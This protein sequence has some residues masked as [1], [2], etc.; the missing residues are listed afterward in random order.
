MIDLPP[1]FKQALGNGVRTS[2]YPLVRIYKGIRIDDTIPDDAESINLSIKETNISGSAYKPLL[3]NTPSIKSSA[4]IINNKYTISSVSLSISNA[5]F[6]G[7]IFSDDI[8][9]ILNAVVQVYYCANGIDSID[10]CLLVYTGTI[11]R[12][13]Q[14]AETI[15]LELEDA[16]QQILSTQIPSTLI[17]DD[18]TYKEDD[19]GKPYPMVY[20]YVDKSP[21][22]SHSIGEDNL[23][24]LIQ[25]LTKF[26]ID[27]E[28][29]ELEGLWKTP[30][31]GDYGNPFLTSSHPLIDNGYIKEV[32]TLSVYED[33]FI[34]IP[35][36][37]DYTQPWIYYLNGITD[38][39]E[40]GYKKIEMSVDNLYQFEQSTTDSSASIKF[41]AEALINETDVVGIPSRIY[42]PLDK[43]VCVNQDYDNNAP[44][45]T[46]ENQNRIYGFTHYDGIGNSDGTGSAYNFIPWKNDSDA[47]TFFGHYIDNWNNGDRT[48]WTPM[49]LHN[50]HNDSGATVTSAIDDSWKIEYPETKGFYPIDNLQDGGTGKGIWI[51]GRNEDAESGFVYVKLYLK[52]NVASFPCSSKIVYDVQYHSFKGMSGLGNESRY[53]AY[54]AEF[55]DNNAS[56]QYQDP[57]AN[58]KLMAQD[59][60][61]TLDF[62]YIPNGN[63]NW[64]NID[65]GNQQ[66]VTIG[67]ATPTEDTVELINGYEELKTFNNT[68]AFENINFGML[69]IPQFDSGTDEYCHCSVQLFNVYLLQDAVIDQPLDKKFFA[70]VAGRIQNDEVIVSA[71]NILKDILEDELN[72]KPDNIELIDEIDSWQHSFTLNEQKEAKEVF[73]GLFKSSLIIPSF[74]AQ[75]QFSFIPLHQ[76]LDNVSYTTIDNQD[77]LKYSFSLT[78]LDDIKNSVNVKYKKNYG[79]GEF[80]KETGYSLIDADD[81]EYENLDEITIAIYPDTLTKHYNIDYYGLTSEEGK[82]E[83]ET[84]YIRDDDT[85][86]KLQKR[87]LMWYANQH[88]ITKID[89]P[90]SYMNLEVGDYIHFNELI[91]GKLAF[92][93][94]YT[95]TLLKNGQ[96]VYPIFFITKISKSLDKVSIEAVQV[97]RGEYGEDDEEI[98][99]DGGTEAVVDGGGTSGQGNWEL[100]D[101]NDNPNY[102]DDT[103][104][105]EE[106][107]EEVEEYLNCNWYQGNNNLNNNPQAIIDTNLE[108]PFEHEIFITYNDEEIVHPDTGEVLIPVI[109]DTDEPFDAS[110]Y[111][112]AAQTN[113]SIILSTPY[114]IPEGHNGI[115]GI[116]RIFYE[117]TEHSVELDFAQNY[118]A[119][120]V[121]ALGDINEDGIINILDVVVLVNIVTS[122]AGAEVDEGDLAD[123]N[124]DGIVNILD[125]VMLINL[126]LTEGNNESPT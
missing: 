21:V 45:E 63:G 22:I 39:D 118:V 75:G 104:V 46:F 53:F 125:A 113:T 48:W 58:T 102:G 103:I 87:L 65:Y 92:G 36:Y 50:N 79:S 105:E 64:R 108:G 43:M 123:I 34:P 35:Q 94:D 70:D 71:Q 126:I 13:S 82:L 56:L 78:K 95:N 27:K 23:G 5:P 85:A 59:L 25:V 6:Q 74:N 116:L 51:I 93:Y 98:F 84:D 111:L 77:I 62:P 20:G 97:H 110:G 42:R 117:G 24:E 60:A 120:P 44:H 32:G 67:G 61:D 88:L 81:N 47:M 2:L 38:D 90:A 17:P 19:I 15:K 69:K 109:G 107:E 91:G 96:V 73:E 57:A 49:A 54:G 119:P 52:D 115:V 86:R 41:N 122:G 9:S 89:L 68:T 3:L 8:Q 40:V 76:V 99:L 26:E 124:G 72:Y 55:F 4:D 83:V 29:K 7:K 11:R 112:T 12:F 14:S 66:N 33:N 106:T 18:F 1:K 121:Y 28:D 16:T 30:N 31:E 114:L 10:D 37:L 101:P 80:D 100:P